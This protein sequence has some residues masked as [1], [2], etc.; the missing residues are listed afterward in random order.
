MDGL[1]AEQDICF[2]PL[3]SSSWLD[4]LS[5]AYLPF[6]IVS[7]SLQGDGHAA[8]EDHVDLVKLINIIGIGPTMVSSL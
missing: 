8:H 4:A 2:R 3:H 7:L 6:K 5:R 1:R